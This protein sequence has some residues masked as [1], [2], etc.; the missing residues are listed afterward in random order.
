MVLRRFEAA[1]QPGGA[2]PFPQPDPPQLFP[3]SAV[4]SAT[5]PPGAVS[6]TALSPRVPPHPHQHPSVLSGQE[7][8]GQLTAPPCRG[9][10]CFSKDFGPTG[11]CLHS[12]YTQ[13]SDEPGVGDIPTRLSSRDPAARQGPRTHGF[14]H[15]S[16]KT[17]VGFQFQRV[18]A[19]RHVVQSS[20]GIMVRVGTRKASCKDKA[21]STRF[22]S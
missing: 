19:Q 4:L 1:E 20:F 11:M 8:S 3:S 15:V 6:P 14:G 9:L 21:D 7:E 12:R 10:G 22:L 13:S 16:A 2:P 18:L 17:H 5:P